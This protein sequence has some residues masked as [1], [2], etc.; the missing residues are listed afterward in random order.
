M[1]VAVT[2][3]QADGAMPLRAK[4]TCCPQCV[5]E[6][7]AAATAAHGTM[8]RAD[9]AGCTCLKCKQW[10]RRF[11]RALE[12]EADEQR[13][14][15]H[16]RDVFESEAAEA[17]EAAKQPSSGSSPSRSLIRRLWPL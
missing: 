12:R 17:A 2:P 6:W 14:E 13:F 1:A 11:N 16:G 7:E 5:A 3:E 10:T 4:P 15:P 9:W 8:A